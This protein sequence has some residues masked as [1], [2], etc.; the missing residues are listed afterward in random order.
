M[1]RATVAKVLFY[2]LIAVSFQCCLLG[3]GRDNRGEVMG[4]P[5]RLGWKM[6]A[7][8]DMM[9]VPGGSFL[10]GAVEQDFASIINTP[11]QVAVS[12]MYVD[13]YPVTNNKY[14]EFIN[15]LLEEA[16]SL[17]DGQDDG[18]AS[19]V[20]ENDFMEATGEASEEHLSNAL[21]EEFIMQELY[22]DMRVWK[23]DFAHHMADRMVE[24]Y[25]EHPSFDNFPV[26][27]ITWE[28]AK[29]FAAWRT[30]SLNAYREERGLWAM[31]QFRLPTAA[32]WTYAARGGEAFAKYPWGGPYVRDAEGNL[33]ANFKSNRGN[34]RECGYDHT[35]PVDYF[36]PNNYGLH[37]GGNVSEWTLDA[38][39]PAAPARMWDLNP[40]YMD[41]EEP[42]KVIKGGSWKDIA[43]FVQTDV[44][45][46]EHKDN[47]RSYIGFRCVMPHIGE[48]PIS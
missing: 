40:V 11:K 41:E 14:R 20:V 6:G 3:R 42:H 1:N 33:L 32:E 21:S 4:V 28:A 31:P 25:Y 37:V 47:A 12:S 19:S 18:I 29:Y 46:Y 23:N 35:S 13:K 8:F 38:Y 27:G 48:E 7:P 15:T 5:G 17:S 24:Y 2:V 43:R 26:V 44:I 39:N 9:F 16:Q 10:I 30:E 22:P 34:A 36:A 45:D